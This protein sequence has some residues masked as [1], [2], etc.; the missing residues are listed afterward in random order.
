MTLGELRKGQKAQ[1]VKGPDPS[2]IGGRLIEFGFVTNAK[3]EILAVAPFGG[4]PIL[5]R[6]QATRVALRRE[7]AAMILVTLIEE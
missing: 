3:L 4:D 7:D 2:G 5:I 6:L 1:I